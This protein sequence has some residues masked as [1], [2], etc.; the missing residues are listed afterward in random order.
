[1]KLATLIRLEFSE[2]ETI[3]TLLLDGRL[4]CWTLEDGPKYFRI[5]EGTYLCKRRLSPRFGETFEIIVAGHTYVEFHWGNTHIDTE[6]CVL[7]GTKVGWFDSDAPP[8]R[9]ILDSKKA[10]LKLMSLLSGV[11]EFRLNIVSINTQGA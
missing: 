5:P 10:F 11:D 9:A 1:M 3:G 6:G 2:M 4:V 8:V 7:C